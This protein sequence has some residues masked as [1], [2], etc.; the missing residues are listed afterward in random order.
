MDLS[1]AKI[2]IDNTGS[3]TSALLELF[4]RNRLTELFNSLSRPRSQAN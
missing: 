4:V 1:T 2:E 3:F